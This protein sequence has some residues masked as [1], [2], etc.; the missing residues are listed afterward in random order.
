MIY[1]EGLMKWFSWFVTPLYW[2]VVTRTNS[3]NVKKELALNQDL[4]VLYI[5]PRRSFIDLLVLDKMC[6]REG[7]PSP[8][9]RLADL[10]K[11]GQ[12]AAIFL[13]KPGFWN[14]RGIPQP[15]PGMETLVQRLSS[16]PKQ[17][18]EI[19]PV[20]VFW[21]NVPGKQKSIFKLIFND[22]EN[23]GIF[24]KLLIILVQGRNNIIHFAKPVSF[25]KLMTPGF[26][27]D[28]VARK[29]RRVLRVHF[30]SQRNIILGPK[31]YHKHRV[32]QHVV[33]SLPIKNYIEETVKNEKVRA[34]RLEARARSYVREISADMNFS[35]LRV[36]DIILN[37]L[38][39]KLF[40]GVRVENLNLVKQLMMQDY[41]I[42]YAP[43]HR[44]HLDY[45]LVNWTLYTQGL[46][47]PHTAAGINLNFFPIGGFLRRGGA[48][49]LRRSF[50]GNKLYGLVFSEYLHF[51][52]T[53]GYPLAFFPEGGR[54]RTGR[55]LPLKTGMISM[56]VQSF[57]RN[58][59]RPIA[60]VPIYLG[61]DK[62]PE[63]RSYLKELRGQSKKSESLMGFFRARKSLKSYFGKVFLNFG[64]PIK[65]Q[66][67]L[68]KH[69]RDWNDPKWK[70]QIRAEWMPR[71]VDDLARDLSAKMNAAATINAV[72]LVSMVMQ[73][74]VHSAMSEDELKLV[75]NC[76]KSLQV[77]LPYSSL[78]INQLL[79]ADQDI[80][81][82][83]KLGVLQR[84]V[85]DG[86][87]VLFLS[88]TDK[89]MTEYYK[90]NILHLFTIPALVAR[91]FA[92]KESMNKDD[93][94]QGCLELY[95]FLREEFFLPWSIKEAEKYLCQ[96]VELFLRLEL[97]LPTDDR[98]VYIRPAVDGVGYQ[99][100]MLL[101]NTLGF[102]FERYTIVSLLLLKY[103][104]GE[105]LD[106][107]IFE[108]QCQSM[109]Q[110]L[111]IL[112]GIVNPGTVDKGL[113][114]SHLTQLREMGYIEV[115]KENRMKISP[116]IK[117]IALR[118]Q[119][120]LSNEAR[121]S[122]LRAT[123]NAIDV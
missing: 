43:V 105:S 74:S 19:V 36:F 111:A 82:V 72:S 42:V 17:D 50:A 33:H 97:L 11:S 108:K 66:E 73:S 57:L 60:I 107:A 61:Y 9:Y 45:L 55:M 75:L 15:A 2:W 81:H 35:V 89:I 29:L 122:I 90:N 68:D 121:M 95:P 63:I 77:K 59:D 67:Y 69:Q 117:D 32:I 38:F 37:R 39:N 106:I 115:D 103:V 94:I 104:D 110:R 100:L 80:A 1:F 123:G 119:F 26:S 21:G 23:A 85:H 58:S 28:A 20:S 86:G 7:L 46:G 31:L 44:S 118:S 16:V 24:Q 65:L 13:S 10:K 47:S 71:V 62:V 56:I 76:F 53:N 4:P 14:K 25:K 54:S 12:A 84:Y 70:N 22:E 79:T 64:E 52:L 83:E 8:K 88:E 102:V 114:R 48:F 99:S 109:A 96:L 93:L 34:I 49:F 6:K 27:E 51:L 101:S 113:F 87:D 41:E 98:L 112:N 92:H 3:S 78:V 5:L 40:D 18:L 120:L 116:S 30:R 91:F